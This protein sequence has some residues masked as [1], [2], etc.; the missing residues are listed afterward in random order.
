MENLNKPEADM[1]PNSGTVLGSDEPVPAVI[2][3]TTN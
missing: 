2:A 1:V 3:T